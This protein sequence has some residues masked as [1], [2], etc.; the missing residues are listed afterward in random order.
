MDAAGADSFVGK[1]IIGL[2]RMHYDILRRRYFTLWRLKTQAFPS[3]CVDGFASSEHHQVMVLPL[4]FLQSS[5]SRDVQQL[6]AVCKES[7]VDVWLSYDTNIDETNLQ[8]L[9]QSVKSADSTRVVHQCVVWP[10]QDPASRQQNVHMYF[11]SVSSEKLLVVCKNVWEMTNLLVYGRYCPGSVPNV[12]YAPALYRLYC[13]VPRWSSVEQRNALRMLTTL[14]RVSAR[15]SRDS[16]ASFWYAALRSDVSSSLLCTL[17]ECTV[18][19]TSFIDLCSL[20]TQR[21]M[22]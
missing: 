12:I 17:K 15:R 11:R 5:D 10:H 16:G 20:Q 6:F 14:V 21:R 3:L 22:E 9:L 4:E 8:R 19:G 18:A 13:P 2:A 1:A 7:L